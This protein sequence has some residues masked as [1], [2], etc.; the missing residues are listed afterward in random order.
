M[1]TEQKPQ[2]KRYFAPALQNLTPE[3]RRKVS[4]AAFEKITRLAKETSARNGGPD[5]TRSEDLLRE[6]RA[7]RTRELMERSGMIPVGDDEA[8]EREM[9]LDEERAEATMRRHIAE[10]ERA[11]AERKAAER[12]NGAES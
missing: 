9:A 12:R 7:E 10:R 3:E 6:I 2:I 11:E 1:A 5:K 8:W 4:H